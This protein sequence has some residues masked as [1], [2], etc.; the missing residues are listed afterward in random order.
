MG[1]HELQGFGGA[2]EVDKLAGALELQI[3]AAAEDL[4]HSRRRA[5][6]AGVLEQ[7]RVVEAAAI[8]LRQR[9]GPGE[10]HSQQARASGVAAGLSLGQI[11][12]V[13][14]RGDDLR[15]RDV[16]GGVVPRLKM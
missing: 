7:Q 6:A 4:R 1:F 5:G 11:E 3:V 12:G 10:P 14:E 2:G 16:L 9:D 15:E 13:G 8:L